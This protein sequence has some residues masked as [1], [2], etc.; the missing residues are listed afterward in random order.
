VTTEYFRIKDNCRTGLVK[1]LERAVSVIPEIDNPEILDIG[2]GTGVPTLW[3]ADKYSG[4]ITAIDTDVNSLDWLRKKAKNR[5]PGERL[6]VLNISFLDFNPDT[7]SFDLILAEGL[8]NIIGFE[9]GFLRVIEMLKRNRYFIIHDEFRD[10]DKKC[11]FIR[12]NNCRII[13][14]QYLDEKIWW[15]DYYKMLETEINNPDNSQIQNLFKSDIKE[16]EYYKE[17]PSPFRSI[18]YIIEKL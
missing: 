17:D 16:I 11:D 6:T 4:S 14:S 10:H 7:E 9:T 15:N 1:Y 3:L 18:Y 13:D 5:R 12:D 8:L 2:C